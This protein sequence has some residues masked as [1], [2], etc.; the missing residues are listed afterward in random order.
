MTE[1]LPAKDDLGWLALADR[2]VEAVATEQDTQHDV[3]SARGRRLQKAKDGKGQLALAKQRVAQAKAHV[4]RQEAVVSKLVGNG[5]GAAKARELLHLMHQAL[6][7]AHRR[8]QLL[9]DRCHA[10][11]RR[12]APRE[13]IPPASALSEP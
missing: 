5:R 10:P 12:H 4:T 7:L 9:L 6:D 13:Q 2:N 3:E 8:R 11:R 1:D